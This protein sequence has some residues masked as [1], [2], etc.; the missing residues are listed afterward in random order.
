MWT[1][2][3][4]L[5]R[6]SY[7]EAIVKVGEGFESSGTSGASILT[8]KLLRTARKEYADEQETL[9]DVPPSYFLFPFWARFLL[10]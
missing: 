6:S 1:E 5:A 3:H 7:R 8:V 10:T 9:S 2:F 4:L